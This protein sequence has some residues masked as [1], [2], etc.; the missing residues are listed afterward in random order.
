MRIYINQNERNFLLNMLLEC[1]EDFLS[2]QEFNEDPEYCELEEHEVVNS[3]L[4]KLSDKE[5]RFNTKIRYVYE[6]IQ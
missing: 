2:D 6:K 5:K 3:L 1:I 4:K